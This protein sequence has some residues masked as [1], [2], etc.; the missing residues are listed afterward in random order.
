MLEQN[1]SQ[2]EY[3]FNYSKGSH[4]IIIAPHYIEDTS[5]C[6]TKT[7]SPKNIQLARQIL[8]SSDSTQIV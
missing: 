2:R 4:T 3:K 5:T 8:F 1:T 7:M 6:H